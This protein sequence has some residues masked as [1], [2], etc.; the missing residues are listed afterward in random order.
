MAERRAYLILAALQVAA[1]LA[2]SA[3]VGGYVWL[4]GEWSGL[5][6]F[7]IGAS[8]GVVHLLATLMS[9][10][11]V[12]RGRAGVAEEVVAATVRR[13]RFRALVIGA[14]VALLQS[15]A[16]M[17]GVSESG[18]PALITAAMLN[19]AIIVSGSL[20]GFSSMRGGGRSSVG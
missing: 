13:W 14:A 19:V 17:D 10:N 6:A 18:S 15:R 9:V 8:L 2:I 7:F 20:L 5:G 1:I 3:A 11:R 12:L 16:I 4:R